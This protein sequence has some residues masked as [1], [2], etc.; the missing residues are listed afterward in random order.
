MQNDVAKTEQAAVLVILP[1]PEEEPISGREVRN[2]LVDLVGRLVPEKPDEEPISDPVRN[3]FIS[4]RHGETV[5]GPAVAHWLD[6]LHETGLVERLGEQ[7]HYRW[8]AKVEAPQLD[9]AFHLHEIHE[10]L[11]RA[12]RLLEAM[13]AYEIGLRKL[14]GAL[15]EAAREPQ[16]HDPQAREWPREVFQAPLYLL[17]DAPEP[18]EILPLEPQPTGDKFRRYRE[19]KHRRGMRLLRIWVPD[20]RR[21]EFAEEAER[22]AKLL[23]GRP[24]EAEALD[25]IE[26]AFDWPDQ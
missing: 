13:Q 26:A 10:A 11:Q 15:R 24:E 14:R 2:R 8:R 18:Q 9:E 23:R 12:L 7:R 16:A 20:P 21:P 25:F 22:Q 4:Y 5:S 1:K 17:Q 6:Q 19:A 3:L